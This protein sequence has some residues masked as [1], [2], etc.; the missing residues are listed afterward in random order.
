MDE[1]IEI[2]RSA[3]P[4]DRHARAIIAGQ[5]QISTQTLKRVAEGEMPTIPTLNNLLKVLL[6]NYSV[7][8]FQNENP[9]T[10]ET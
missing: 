8:L 1:I 9:A 7:R 6:P 2:V 4:E 3:I 10:P 5:A